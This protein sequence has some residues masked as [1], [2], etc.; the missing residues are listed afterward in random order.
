MVFL[1]LETPD[2]FEVLRWTLT[3]VKSGAWPTMTSPGLS[4]EVTWV[5]VQELTL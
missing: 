3:S 5:A 2:A 1:I 4:R